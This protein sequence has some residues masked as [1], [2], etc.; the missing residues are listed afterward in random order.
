MKVLT[1]EISWHPGKDGEGKN[2]PILSLTFHPSGVLVTAGHDAIIRFWKIDLTLPPPKASSDA[3][4]ETKAPEGP[5][6]LCAAELAG[7]VHAV[8]VV[9]FSPNFECLASAGDDGKAIIWYANR[10][11]TSANWSWSDIKSHKELSSTALSGHGGDV[12][13]VAWSPDGTR[14]VTASIDNSAIIWDVRTG[15]SIQI[16]R[17][18]NHYVQGVAWDVFDQ[19]IATQSCDRTCRLYGHQKNKPI[20]STPGKTRCLQRAV[21]RHRKFENGAINKSGDAKASAVSNDPSKTEKPAPRSVHKKHLMFMDDTV[22]SFFRRPC[23]SPCGSM[24]FSPAGQFL[25]KKTER[26]MIKTTYMHLRNQ[27]DRPAFHYP[28]YG[29]ASLVVKCCPVLFQRAKRDGVDNI[30]GLDYRIVFAIATIDEVLIYDTQCYYPIMIVKNIHYATITDLAWACDG[31]MLA[32]SSQDGYCTFIHLIAGE[33]GEPLPQAKV[34][35]IMKRKIP[36]IFAAKVVGETK[37]ESPTKP[38]VANATTPVMANATTPAMDNTTTPVTAV[39]SPP[40]ESTMAVASP[41]ATPTSKSAA[42]TSQ[43]KRITPIF[44]GQ[45]SAPKKRSSPDY[46]FGARPKRSRT[47]EIPVDTQAD[48][49]SDSDFDVENM[50]AESNSE[51]DSDAGEAAFGVSGPTESKQPEVVDVP[52][53]RKRITPML[54]GALSLNTIPMKST[55]SG[56]APAVNAAVQE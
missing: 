29:E 20:C 14:I 53:E 10:D 56:P 55:E 1:P 18:H 47:G 8:N 32:V 11:L 44:V 28:G 23:F 34:P 46:G 27:W 13:D 17:D 41:P 42:Q 22:P 6:I 3:T 51:D 21:M 2:D 4:A 31:T 35:E 40:A 5:S 37:T 36:R 39:T 9:R 48:E 7:H 50:V 30:P 54:V 52:P 43:K 12:T 38:A 45:V 33:L 19:F 24:F 16:L 15:K 25:S 49:D 26:Q